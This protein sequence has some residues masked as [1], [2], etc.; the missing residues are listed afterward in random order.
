MVLCSVYNMSVC[1]FTNALIYF[2]YSL[3]CKLFLIYKALVC[4]KYKLAKSIW[5]PGVYVERILHVL[6]CSVFCESFYKNVLAL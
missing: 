1:C 4:C 3:I 5:C 2:S 6:V